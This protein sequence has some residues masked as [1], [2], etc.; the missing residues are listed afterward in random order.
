MDTRQFQCRDGV[1]VNTRT[2]QRHHAHRIRG[3]YL[4]C[5]A[6]VHETVRLDGRPMAPGEQS[7]RSTP[8]LSTRDHRRMASTD[9]DVGMYL[10]RF[11][12]R[13]HDFLAQQ[14]AQQAMRHAAEAGRHARTIARARR[15]LRR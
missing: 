5:E 4:V 8:T 7:P 1:C 3:A 14:A 9:E 12:A 15:G 6:G 2:G 10:R 11:V 13:F